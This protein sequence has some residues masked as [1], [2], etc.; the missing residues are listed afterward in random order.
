ML[1]ASSLF[2]RNKPRGQSSLFADKTLS[3]AASLLV[4][5][6]LTAAPAATTA[7]AQGDTSQTTQASA[8]Q[9]AMTDA[10]NTLQPLLGQVNNALSSVDARRWKTPNDVR[11]QTAS[12][13]QSI[14]RD[15][16]GTLPGLVSSAQSAPGSIAPAFAVFRNIDA[17]Y[18][19]LLRITETATLAGSQQE[20]TRLEQVRSDLQ[21]RRNQ[22]GNAILSS[23]TAQDANV[24]SLQSALRAANSAASA[25]AAPKKVVVNDGPDSA[26]KP[27][28]KR[29]PAAAAKAAVPAAT[30]PQ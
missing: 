18:D 10:L 22:L 6:F 8:P 26:A 25:A 23:A 16:N 7:L 5:T 1:S 28:K 12:D 14:Q 19:V 29:K 21:S 27:V 20:A 30:P 3:A 17:L 15:L 13:I 2:R 4:L 11:D 24:T 9:L